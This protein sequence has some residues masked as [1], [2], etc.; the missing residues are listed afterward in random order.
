VPPATGKRRQEADAGD[1]GAPLLDRLAA[2]AGVLATSRW[3][4]PAALVLFTLALWARSVVCPLHYWDDNVY[5]FEDPRLESPGPANLWRILTRP[6]FANY[7]PVTTLTYAFDRAVWGNRVPGFH[8]TQ[9]A[10]YAGG[11]LVLYYLFRAVLKSPWA[12]LFA[13]AAYSAHTVHVESVAWLASRK[14]VVCLAFCAAAVLAYVRYEGEQRRPWRFYATSLALALAA[15]LSKGYAV[16]LPGVLVAYDL[17]FAERFRRRRVYDK[18]PFLALAGAVTAFTI[19]AQGKD[20]A[21]IPSPVTPWERLVLLCKIFAVYVGRG[22]LPVR[23]SAEYFVSLEWLPGWAALLGASLG[24][25]AVAGFVLL[26]RR[27]PAVAFGIALFC[28]PLATVMNTFW[29]LRTWITDRYLLFPTIGSSL[30]LAGAGLWLWRRRPIAD[31]LPRPALAAAAAGL[32]VL[33]SALTIA[34]IGVWT[35][36]VLLWSDVLRKQYGFPGSGPVGPREV[37]GF[38]TRE[39]RL[40]DG[41]VLNSLAW[42]YRRSGEERSAEELFSLLE[43]HRSR[44]REGAELSVAGRAIEAGRYDEAIDVL[45]PVAEGDTWPAADAWRMIGRAQAGKGDLE[46][47]RESFRKAV[48]LLKERG[49]PPTHALLDLGGAEYRAGNYERAAEAYRRLSESAPTDPR[50]V[51]YRGLALERLGRVAEAYEL[52]EATLKLRGE[53]PPTFEFDFADVRKQMALAAE[54]IG[55]PEAAAR[56]FEECLRLRPDHPEREAIRAKIGWLRT[57]GRR[58]PPGGR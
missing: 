43:G 49:R 38:V 5:L 11:V 21:L 56:H 16:V 48:D 14:D 34:R 29:T 9:L 32:V 41:K 13:A 17:C 31:R 25:G 26:R 8:L 57:V 3:A 42:S 40:P 39:K 15:M 6:F 1:G 28:L 35:E 18:L 2:A 27:L 7:H 10:F 23:L 30:A 50:G 19:L 54:K 20:T 44:T 55:R 12:G 24:V 58:L 33:Y 22:L 46:G 51:F 45:A 37:R 47:A 4:L 53:T 36:P 52:Y